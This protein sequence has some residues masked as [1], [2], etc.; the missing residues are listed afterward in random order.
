MCRPTHCCCCYSLERG[1]KRIAVLGLIG[2]LSM[3]LL[4][5]TFS[6]V[7]GITANACNITGYTA[8]ILWVF[9]SAMLLAGTL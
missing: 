6:D 3:G 9:A 4:H 1:C 8:H 7:L 2:G 5:I